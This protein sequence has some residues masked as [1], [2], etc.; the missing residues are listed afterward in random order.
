[1]VFFLLSS[2]SKGQAVSLAVT[3]VAVDYLR[4]RNLFDLKLIAEKSIY[5]VIGLIFGIIA[6]KA[7]K[8][9][10]ALQDIEHFI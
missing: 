5:L 10:M 9:G 1:M 8:H 7:Q 4:N 6:I 3:L 2:L